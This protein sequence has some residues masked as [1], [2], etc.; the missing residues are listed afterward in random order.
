LVHPW[1]MS[2]ITS[3]LQ[4][5]IPKQLADLYNLRAGDDVEFVAAGPVIRLVPPSLR[6]QNLLP[7]EER[8][9]IFDD[10]TARQDEIDATF[11]RPEG[12]LP[13]DRG[14]TREELYDRGDHR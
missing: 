6:K 11:P 12:A 10:A 3:K 8:L 14:W 2:K 5:T 4:V 7:L 9:R 1:L 13:V